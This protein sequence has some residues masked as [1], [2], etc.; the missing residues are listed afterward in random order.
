MMRLNLEMNGIADPKDPEPLYTQSRIRFDMD[1]ALRLI[2]PYPTNFPCQATPF[3]SPFF[4]PIPQA[5]P[6][7][8][9]V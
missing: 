7:L 6:F 1:S 8:R 5:A 2:R 3:C 4:Y 9:A